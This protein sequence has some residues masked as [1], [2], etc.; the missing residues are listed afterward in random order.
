MIRIGTAGWS[1]PRRF[2]AQFAPLGSGL[3]RYAARFDAVEIN[4]TFYRSHR[5][6]T[7]ARWSAAVPDGFRFS[8]KLP[9]TVTHE[10][11]L[12]DSAEILDAFLDEVSQLGPLLGPLLIQLPPSLAFELAVAR[13][14][15]K[16][17]RSRT[18]GDIVCEPRHATWF[19]GEGDRLLADFRVARVAADPARVPEAAFP[20]GWPNPTYFRLHGSPRMYYSEYGEAFMAD[21]AAQLRSGAAAETWCIFDNTVSGAAIGNALHLAERLHS[22]N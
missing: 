1:V 9:K 18:E 22:V 12:N 2:A 19:E 11:R 21:L 10:R 6:Q 13:S 5:P 15:L 17:L 3:E 4:S 20:G 7:Y 16:L 14:F 8:V